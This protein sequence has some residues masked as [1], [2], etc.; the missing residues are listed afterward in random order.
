MRRYRALTFLANVLLALTALSLWCAAPATA[1]GDNAALPDQGKPY[2]GAMLDWGSDNASDFAG[3]L[4][5]SP[6]LYAHDVSFPMTETEKRYVREFLAQ[7]GAQGAHALL[8]VKPTVPLSTID[9]GS[10]GAFV[11]ELATLSEGFHGK[12][13]ISFAPAMNASWVSWGQ[14]PQAY[15]PAFRT[16]AGAVRS[17][18]PGSALVWQPFQGWGYP[19]SKARQA[20]NPGQAGFGDLDSNHDGAWDTKDAAYAPYYP[21]DDIVDWVGLSAFHDDSGGA[22]GSNTLPRQ[23]EFAS[24]LAGNGTA[25]PSDADFYA[26]Y[27][28]K[29]QKPLL[30]ETSA[31]FSPAANGSPES[32]IKTGWW[33][34]VISVAS[35]PQYGRI[36]AIVWD[37]TTSVRDTGDL[38]VDWRL[39]HRTNIAATAKDILLRSPLVRGPVTERTAG[40]GEARTVTGPAAWAVTAS[41]L[42]AACCLWLLPLRRREVQG[43]AYADPSQ[44]DRRID[45]LRGMAIVFVVVDHLGM[46]SLFQLFTQETIGVVSG[47]ELFVLLSGT[48]LG[49]VYGPRAKGGV[50]EIAEKTGRRA[51]KLYVTALAV[52][53]AVFLL[54][55]I[56]QMNADALTTFT[57][58]GT[59]AAGHAASG[60]SYDLYSGMGDLLHYPTPPAVIPAILLLQFGPWQFNIMGLYVIMLLLSPLILAA[61]AR[62]KV[63]LVLL[64][65]FLLYAAGSVLH[66]RLLPSQFEDSFPLSVWQILFILGMA[67]GYYRRTIVAWF[68][69][70]RRRLLVALCAVLTAGFALFSWANPYAVNDFAFRL[71]V[72]PSSEFRSFYDAY[73]GRTYL[74]PGRLLNVVVLVIS[75]YAFLTAYWKLVERALGWLLI[76]LGQATLY[77]FVVHVF[78]ILAISNI[79]ALQQGNVWLNTGAYVLILGLLWTMVRTRFL[80]RVIPR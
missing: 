45:L 34:Q 38:S 53:V 60:R 77:V 16:F 8:S 21:G 12:L 78:L 42:V 71:G 66:L 70:P 14:Q 30:V 74:G 41:V 32:D 5:A 27:A 58:Q 47:A 35:S 13:L 69:D 51:G 67:A 2:L 40:T 61:F 17:K 4:G 52:V 24:M 39:T 43:W 64:A 62:G 28:A 11:D 25:T 20:P 37:E 9:S 72:L 1:S 22:Q 29:R 59:G 76:P 36:G 7:A 26:D 65:S 44:R 57:D 54:S 46:T 3:R 19:F 68:S 49:M 33:N 15:R 80:F 55:L 6:A 18:L 56:P 50:G 48:I 79:P 63:V 75:A 23:G 73:F 31:Y 10:A